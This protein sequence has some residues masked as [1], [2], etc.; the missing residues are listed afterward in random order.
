MA[1]NRAY[2]GGAAPLASI[3]CLTETRKA[4]GDTEV[5]IVGPIYSKS[6]RSA[7]PIALDMLLD[8]RF[9]FINILHA[10]N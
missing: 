8:C 9:T 4:Q 10:K 1:K 3:G 7:S 6:V 5:P 2:S